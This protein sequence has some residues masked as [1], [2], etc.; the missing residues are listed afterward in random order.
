MST[1]YTKNLMTKWVLL[2]AL[3]GLG[4]TVADPMPAEAGN[5][6]VAPIK[7]FYDAKTRSEVVTVS[8]DGD[9]PL[10]LD[11]YA[12]EWTQD[13]NGQDIYQPATDLV[14]FPKHLTIEPKKERVIRT[15]IKTPPVSRE[16]TYRLF[17][18][19]VP[20]RSQTA[21]TSVAIA[22]QF[23][24]PIFAK[25]PQEKVT[26]AITE[27]RIADS[28]LSLLLENHGNSHFRINT[29]N[30]QGMLANGTP[31]FQESING[32]YLLGGSARN[33]TIAIPPEKCRQLTILDI[34]VDADRIDFN[35]RID[36]DP[37]MC[38]SP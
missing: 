17:I 34:Q 29:I 11:I 36:V 37:T 35:R 3:T 33:L 27:A 23:G 21:Q 8:N 28:S 31:V 32:W 26:G 20:D 4:F 14:F 1:G 30:V 13:Q 15:G 22:I 16:K 7:V 25:P 18:K 9:Q 12:M 6:R 5:W 2:L 10:F 38:T 19:E 24:V